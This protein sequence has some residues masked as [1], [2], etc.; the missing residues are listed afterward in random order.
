MQPPHCP[1]PGVRDPDEY[2]GWGPMAF[3]ADVYS[4]ARSRACWWYI[5]RLSNAFYPLTIFFLCLY[6]VSSVLLAPIRDCLSDIEA[7][8]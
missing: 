2:P 6:L 3:A 7:K 8:M 5:G 4:L 1:P